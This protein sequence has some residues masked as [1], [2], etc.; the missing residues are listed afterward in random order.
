MTNDLVLGKG[1]QLPAR[2]VVRANNVT[3]DGNDATLTGPGK[4]GNPK[5]L[6]NA[7]VAILIEGATGVTVEQQP[8]AVLP[9]AW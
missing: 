4:V 1:A 3:I 2:L 9:P 7:G 5:S 8:C 6:E